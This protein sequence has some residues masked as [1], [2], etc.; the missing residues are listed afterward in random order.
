MPV[1]RPKWL[2]KPNPLVKGKAKVDILKFVILM[3]LSH[4]I[5]SFVSFTFTSAAITSPGLDSG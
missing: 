5:S 4:S 1:I 3:R 2:K